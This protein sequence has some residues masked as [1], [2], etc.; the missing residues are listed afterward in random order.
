MQTD[1]ARFLGNAT[2]LV[3]FLTACSVEGQGYLIDASTRNGSFE[4]GISSSWGGIDAVLMDASFAADGEWFG[5]VQSTRRTSSWQNL[6]VDPLLGRE[7]F[8]QFDARIGAPG[9]DTVS[10]FINAWN[11]DGTSVLPEFTALIGP[12]LSTDAWGHYERRFVFPSDLDV[13]SLRVGL[14]M[15][16]GDGVSTYIGYFD[17]V[18]VEQIPEPSSSLLVL[19]AFGVMASLRLVMR[20]HNKVTGANSR[21]A[22]PPEAGRQSESASCAPPSPSAAVAQFCRWAK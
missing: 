18:V 3:A 6:T 10:A 19:V 15:S 7:F 9:F 2:A 20:R 5:Q 1:L 22:S 14:D 12:P 13:T 8:V 11:A 17:N 16:G 4:D 21:P